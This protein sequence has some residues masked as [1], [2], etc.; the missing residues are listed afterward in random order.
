MKANSIQ[1]YTHRNKQEGVVL[2][3]GLVMMLLLT[4]IGMAAIRSSSMQE[5][6]ASNI[7]DRN[8]AFQACEAAL[9]VAE[10]AATNKSCTVFDGTNGCY[11]DQNTSA[12]IIGWSDQQWATNSVEAAIDLSLTK[13]PRYVIEKIS[14]AA[15][16]SSQLGEGIDYSGGMATNTGSNT[17]R[18][19]C[20]GYGGTQDSQVVLQSTFRSTSI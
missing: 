18:I 14:S 17:Y 11:A 15:G 20:L 12:P 9:R 3:V 7:K 6:M 5:L 19:T 2:I 10:A 16:A 8:L 4:I 13:K 1:V